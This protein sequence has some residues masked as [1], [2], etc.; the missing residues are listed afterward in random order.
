MTS[1]AR[2]VEANKPE[3]FIIE[4]DGHHEQRPRA[5]TLRKEAHLMVEFR[6]GRVIQSDWFLDVEVLS[7]RRRVDWNA[8]V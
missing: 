6:R 4:N 5:Q 7:Q 3:H 1:R 8:G 2:V